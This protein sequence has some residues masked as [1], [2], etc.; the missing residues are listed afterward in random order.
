M[1]FNTIN[2]LFHIPDEGSF[3]KKLILSKD[4]VFNKDIKP[5]FE[6]MQETHSNIKLI[7][8][9]HY[10]SLMLPTVSE[11]IQLEAM[12][13]TT[14]ENKKHF[15]SVYH[16]ILFN[17]GHV[18]EAD[19]FL[20]TAAVVVNAPIDGRIEGLA[21]L[22][23]YQIQE[24][25][26]IEVTMLTLSDANP[27]I[28]QE[29]ILPFVMNAINRLML[30]SALDDVPYSRPTSFD[31]LGRLISNYCDI[32]LVD[33]LQGLEKLSNWEDDVSKSEKSFMP[34]YASSTT[35]LM[36][37]FIEHSTLNQ[38][39]EKGFDTIKEYITDHEKPI[40]LEKIT[41]TAD[42]LNRFQ[43]LPH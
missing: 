8:E 11:G 12:F 24:A 20:R 22:M 42:T 35:C 23:N 33:V 2:G 18:I 16:R 10:F 38:L 15:L 7:Q 36:F 41:R 13:I 19:A 37:L 26:N 1:A 39:L 4:T 25:L 29:N 14:Q 31:D 32:A 9:E 6:L 34:N 5:V 3:L 43:K 21:Y 17:E 40:G 28:A 30:A 27:T